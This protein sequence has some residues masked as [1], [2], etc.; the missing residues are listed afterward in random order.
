MESRDPSC[1][2][3]NYAGRVMLRPWRTVS[4]INACTPTSVSAVPAPLPVPARAASAS[5][6]LDFHD[7]YQHS[8]VS[9]WIE[10]YSEIKR[11]LDALRARG[12]SDLGAHLDAHPELLGIL[13]GAIRVIKVN[14][15]TLKLFR[16]PTRE[17]LLSNLHLVF[18]DE[19]FQRFRREL[20]HL[21]DGQMEMDMETV[22]HALDGTPLYLQLSRS[23]LPGHEGDWSRILISLTDIGERRQAIE[24][25]ERN[26]R[27]AQ[28]LFEHSPASLWVED[29]SAVKAWMGKLRARGVVH[30]APYLAA[31]PETFAEVTPLI[32]VVEV[33]RQT[34][35]LFR[36]ASYGE[37]AANMHRVFRDETRPLWERTMLDM[38]NGRIN[39]EYEGV[40]YALDGNRLE[41]V[42]RTAPLAGAEESWDRVLIAVTDI[43]ARKQAEAHITYLGTHDVL[44]GLF[45]RAHFE[46]RVAQAQQEERYPASIV[47]LDL[48]GLKQANDAGGHEAGDAL[49]R[50]AGEAIAQVA[51]PDDVAARLG[52]DEFA[53]LLPCGGETAAQV[54]AA[55][56]AALVEESN[57]AN[58]A[59]PLSLSIGV[60]TGYTGDE[61]EQVQK[62][63]D[64]RMYEAKRA[65]YRDCGIGDRRGR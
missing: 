30:L 59:V 46:Q 52:G 14:D 45:N 39:C 1:K 24:R 42:L 63:A 37:L 12:V 20:Q 9:L 61:L 3:H 31:H 10:D 22:N 49:L 15:H 7:V 56:I 2:Q 5:E 60:A 43:T 28:G 36:A 27:Y 53:L 40:N 19:M 48:N 8:R 44:T 26:E 6:D 25:A 57:L 34:L 18:R 17:A 21:W 58:P 11:E 47:M 23:I 64:R 33:N 35:R 50:R 32:R 29:F 54:A 13:V 51:G 65:H 41:I 55:R 16:A 38:W 4:P 62:L